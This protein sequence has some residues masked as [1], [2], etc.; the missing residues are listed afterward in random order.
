[1]Y[2]RGMEQA[3]SSK[4]AAPSASSK[5]ESATR[6]T[7]RA[8]AVPTSY[9]SMTP[10]CTR[11]SPKRRPRSARI[12]AETRSK[13]CW[14]MRPSATSASPR[15]SRRRLL[16]A[17]TSRPWSK[18]A[19]LTMRPER[20][21]R[22]PLR[23]SAESR[24]HGLGDRARGDVGEHGAGLLSTAGPWRQGAPPGGR[25]GYHPGGRRGVSRRTPGRLHDARRHRRQRERDR[26]HPGHQ[27]ADGPHHGHE[28]RVDPRAER[29]RGA[30]LRDPRD[31]DLRPRGGGGRRRPSRRPG[32]RRR[33]WTSWSSPP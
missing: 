29:G 30:A 11:A 24:L 7:W 27:R 13:S 3:R 4:T 26:P 21:C 16:A 10:A 23:R 19:I 15:R 8:T 2:S 33:R 25:G 20:T 6:R 12:S 32:W 9:R 31:R 5:S 18:K 28:R 22:S 1:M 14:V 17:K